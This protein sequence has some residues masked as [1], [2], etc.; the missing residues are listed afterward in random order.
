MVVGVM[1]IERILL[2]LS[3]GFFLIIYRMWFLYILES[4]VV[5]WVPVIFWSLLLFLGGLSYIGRIAREGGF[6]RENSRRMIRYALAFYVIYPIILMIGQYYAWSQNPL[7][8]LLLSSPLEEKVP[9]P[10][11]IKDLPVSKSHL[12]YFVF[13]S[14]G[15]F[16]INTILAVGMAF[17]FYLFLKS[18]RKRKDRFFEEGEIEF[19][20]LNALIVGWPRFVIFIPLVF[21]SVVLVS[22]ARL[23]LFKERYTTLGYP[24]LLAAVLT[25]IFGF[26]FIS[27]FKLSALY[28]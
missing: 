2:L 24:F 17:L 18:L 23:F 7:S 4:P 1:S 6:L 5:G 12:G 16:W 26:G 28:I 13:Y 20:F 19:G 8:K 14:F 10:Q 3:P 21:F 25:M 27:I 9:A 11:F 22:L 15:R